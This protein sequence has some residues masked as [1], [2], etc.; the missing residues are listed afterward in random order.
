MK[1]MIGVRKYCSVFI[2]EFFTDLELIS[3]LQMAQQNG[4]RNI[5]FKISGYACG[6]RLN[7]VLFSLL[8]FGRLDDFDSGRAFTLLDGNTWNLYFEIPS[9]R[10]R[11]SSLSLDNPPDWNVDEKAIEL[12]TSQGRTIPQ[13]DL[14]KEMCVLFSSKDFWERYL[15]DYLELPSVFYRAAENII[16]VSPESEFKFDDRWS[17]LVALFLN[18]IHNT[19]Q[20]IKQQQA[21]SSVKKGKKF[22]L[23]KKSSAPPKKSTKESNLSFWNRYFGK[24][25]K[26]T[27]DDRKDHELFL[28]ELSTDIQSSA[29]SVFKS[30]FPFIHGSVLNKKL[31]QKA[32][33]S[34]LGF[35]FDMISWAD[36]E[37]SDSKSSKT[38]LKPTLD[39]DTI[40]P[41]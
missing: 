16:I 29:F 24:K 39:V 26:E 41:E 33:I 19:S 2:H 17:K 40:L 38:K 36:F 25:A 4:I 15:C 27:S 10:N 23:F 11:V 34:H 14:W 20:R 5:A 8:V 9:F 22:T 31:F 6:Q 21:V 7:Q 32:L 3:Q 30:L 18:S 12:L 37:T 35:Y 28:P 13:D 1:S